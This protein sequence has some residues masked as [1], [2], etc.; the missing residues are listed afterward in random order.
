MSILPIKRPGKVVCV[1][2]NYRDHAAEAG[3]ALPQQPILFAK[4]P[5]S[6]VGSCDE[7]ELPLASHQVDYEAELGVVIG[8]TVRDID[9]EHAYDAV[10]GYVCANDISARDVQ[11]GDGQWTRGKSYDTFCPVGPALV[12]RAAVPDPHALAIRCMVNGEVVQESN[13]A[14]MIFS[15]PEI[16]AF[17][18]RH[19][20]LEAGDLICTGTPAGV[21]L[22]H[23]PP[24]WLRDG[25]EVVVE[26][27]G[28][29]RLRNRVVRR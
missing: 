17:A 16:I 27:D 3:M 4:W 19:T 28:I 9:V 6:L 29:G 20:T 1:G 12:P 26:I 11:L 13:T 25:D 10:A 23:R 18:S 22:A 8:R 21:G 24:R 15:V 14:E 7:I 2:L 5:T